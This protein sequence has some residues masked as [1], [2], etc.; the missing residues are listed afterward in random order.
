MAPNLPTLRLDGNNIFQGATLK[1]IDG[2]WSLNGAGVRPDMRLLISAT[3]RALLRWSPFEAIVQKPGAELPDVDELNGKVP[4]EQWQ[5]GLDSRP[6]APWSL[7]R[8]VYGLDPADATICTHHNSTYGTMQAV[9]E[10]ES[11]ITWMRALR[12]AEV[13]PLVKLGDAAMK[14]QYGE[15]RRPEFVIVGWRV[16]AGPGVALQIADQTA[17]VLKAVEPLDLGEELA[18]QVPY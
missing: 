18:D 17:N 3:S 1:F 10:L 12:G 2:R 14:T 13:L 16:F 8:F 11:R 9:H 15:R 7:H 4:R 6:R 5:I